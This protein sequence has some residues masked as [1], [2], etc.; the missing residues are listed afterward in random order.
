MID[1]FFCRLAMAII[2]VYRLTLR[3][4]VGQQCRFHPT[5]S[6][7]ALE[8]FERYG[9]LRGAWLTLRRIGRCHPLHAGGFDP[10]PETPSASCGESPHVPS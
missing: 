9:T 7:Y 6:A 3:P 8:A 1:R 5:C 2:H 10:V 4:F